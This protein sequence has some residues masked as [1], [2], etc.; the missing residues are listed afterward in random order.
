[1]GRFSTCGR[2]EHD[3]DVTVAGGQLRVAKALPGRGLLCYASGMLRQMIRLATV[4]DL[5]GVARDTAARWAVAAGFPVLRHPVLGR[6]GPSP[7]YLHIND[8]VA[9]VDSTLGHALDLAERRRLVER[10]R[11]ESRALAHSTRNMPHQGIDDTPG[12]PH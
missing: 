3:S 1:M 7:R 6:T 8:A 5:L 11:R 10:M 4:A 12:V 2:N 9:L